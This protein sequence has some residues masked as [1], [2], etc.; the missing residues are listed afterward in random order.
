[1]SDLI[2]KDKA[3]FEEDNRTYDTGGTCD[4]SNAAGETDIYV[5]AP[6]A[7]MVAADRVILGRGTIREEER[8]VDSVAADDYITLTV[9]TTY[10]HTIDADTTVD[11]ESASAQ[12]VLSVTATTDFLVGETV[13]VDSGETHEATYII[14]SVQGGISLTMTTDLLFTHEVAEAVAQTGIGG[15]VEVI[16]LTESTVI[17]K[18]NCKKMAISLPSTWQEAGITFLGCRTTNGTFTQ[19]VKA[20]DIA[21]VAIA[22]VAASKTIGMDGIVME[23][24]EAV[25]FIKLRSGT[26]TA[27]IDQKAGKI[28]TVMVVE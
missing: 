1:M 2:Y 4:K 10:N 18:S 26:L 23:A 7:P 22:S 14:L 5:A 12:A 9:A 24:L 13:V 21:E 16:M 28:I 25:P 20:T 6:T 17:D 27:P 8:V 3:I 19:I 11:V 15:V